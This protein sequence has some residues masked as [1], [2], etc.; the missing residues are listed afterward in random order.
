MVDAVYGL[1]CSDAKTFK[2]RVQNV[3]ARD[4]EP[5]PPFVIQG[6][7][8]INE[9]A[10]FGV[11]EKPELPS[12]QTDVESFL[13]AIKAKPV[14]TYREIEVATGISSYRVAKVAAKAGWKKSGKLWQPVAKEPLQ[15]PTPDPLWA[16]TPNAA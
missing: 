13:K 6:R 9:N 14:A 11:L 1:Q 5:V 15:A 16:Q 8:Y 2:L 12:E 3:K 4:F 10:D 7:P